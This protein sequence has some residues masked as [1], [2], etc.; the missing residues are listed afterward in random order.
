MTS[1]SSPRQAGHA[2]RGVFVSWNC[3]HDV[4]I[5]GTSCRAAA[6]SALRA[7]LRPRCADYFG[8]RDLAA[9][10]PVVRIDQT[11]RAARVPG[12]SRVAARVALGFTPAGLRIILAG[13]AA[14]RVATGC[15]GRV[16]RRFG[17][18][19][20][21]FGLRSLLHEQGIPGT[22]GAA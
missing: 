3:S 11:M 10:C 18:C 14:L 5:L 19:V 4:L 16:P 13:R 17:S 6:F 8:D 9:V 1:S 20:I 22:R 21:R 7:G 15:G 2:S 12:A